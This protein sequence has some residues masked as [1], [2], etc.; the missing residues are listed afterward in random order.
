MLLP[1]RRKDYAG[2]RDEA[3]RLLGA[4]EVVHLAGT[5]DDGAP[6]LRTLH[7]VVL[8]D[9]LYFHGA[10]AG[11]KT[12]LEGRTVVVQAEH[13]VAEVPSYALDPVRACPATTYYR[14]A[15]ARGVLEAETD[16]AQK[17]RVLT[18][19]MEKYQPE[20][21]Y[22]PI[23][24]KDPR[25]AGAVRGVAVYRV[26]LDEV[27]GKDKRG[28]NKTDTERARICEVLWRRGQDRDVRAV[29]EIAAR[30]PDEAR[31]AFLTGP[32]G[33]RLVAGCDEDRAQ[34]AAQLVDGAYWNRDV[35][36]DTLA[37]AHRGAGAWVGAL[38]ADGVLIATAR[39]VTDG[40][41]WAMVADV[42]VAPSW[43]GRGVGAAVM[44]LLLDHPRVRGVQFVRLATQDAQTFYERLGF[45]RTGEMLVRTHHTSE[46]MVWHGRG[47]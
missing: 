29:D 30:L 11:E 36:A 26:P 24:E 5:L 6:V 42:A 33:V 44:R 2:T 46:W 8:G 45:V 38:D 22:A 3:V 23:D 34:Q 10:K 27:V 43:R 32:G 16:D 21:G 18:A 15:Q 12:G 35:T 7:A 31:P 40:A 37:R 28:Q 39:S 13:I 1:M 41:K 14:S 19:L 17:A 9:V 4:T 47:A 20:A 25:Y